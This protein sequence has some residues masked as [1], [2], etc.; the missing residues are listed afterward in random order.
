MVEARCGKFQENVILYIP[1]FFVNV[2]GL[3]AM[4]QIEIS[5]MCH[6]RKSGHLWVFRLL[7]ARLNE[8]DNATDCS[9]LS[10]IEHCRI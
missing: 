9:L 5:S 6:A 2:S 1:I 3:R 10:Q 4:T 7:D 8:N